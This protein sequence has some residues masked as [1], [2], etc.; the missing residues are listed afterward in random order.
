M[1]HCLFCNEEIDINKDHIE[2]MHLV[3]HDIRYK[4]CRKKLCIKKAR[5]H[6]FM[7]FKAWTNSSRLEFPPPDFFDGI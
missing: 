7:L 6:M 2:A 1:I 5:E 4:I 3:D